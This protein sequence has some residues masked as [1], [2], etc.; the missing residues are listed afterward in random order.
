MADSSTGVELKKLNVAANEYNGAPHSDVERS[1]TPLR[2]R[3]S[4]VEKL[5][6]LG[7]RQILK[8]RLPLSALNKF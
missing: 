5:A 2:S 3:D 8:V 6:R 1:E 4:D 7:K